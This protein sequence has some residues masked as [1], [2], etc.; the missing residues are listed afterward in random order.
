[1]RPL[2][3]GCV[4]CGC[5][6]AKRS[7]KGKCEPAEIA[8]FSNIGIGI[9]IMPKGAPKGGNP[10]CGRPKGSRN[11]RT[12]ARLDMMN[13]L[14]AGGDKPLAVM[15][16][17]MRFFQSEALKVEAELES[18]AAHKVLKIPPAAFKFLLAKVKQAYGL[19]EAA[20]KCAADAAQYVH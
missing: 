16:D 10:R 17:N 11:K 20:Q 15:L 9:S 13:H 3:P 6:P 4:A 18:E 14:A 12:L 19:R 5:E 1:S 8:R 7:R 2:E